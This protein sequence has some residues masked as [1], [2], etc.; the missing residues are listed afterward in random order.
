MGQ[1]AE[2][3]HMKTWANAQIDR[4][5]YKKNT[6]KGKLT[7]L[8]Q[9]LSILSDDEPRDDPNWILENLSSI[10]NR[11]AIKNNAKTET[12]SEYANRVKTL[13]EDYVRFLADPKGFKPKSTPTHTLTGGDSKPKKVKTTATETEVADS[14]G[15]RFSSYPLKGNRSIEYRTDAGTEGKALLTVE[16]V[17]RF[18]VSLAS[19]ADDFDITNPEHQAILGMAKRLSAKRLQLPSGEE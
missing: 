18:T 6:M 3:Q 17:M 11:Y 12:T 1:T 8:D 13:I 7:A 9:F 14:T 2:T 5:V 16:D 10:A 4:G 19:Q 15:K